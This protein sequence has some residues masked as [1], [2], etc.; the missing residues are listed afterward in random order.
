MLG[1]RAVAGAAAGLWLL[2]LAAVIIWGRP[3]ALRHAGAIVIMG[4]AQYRG[5]PSPVLRARLD[6][7][8]DLWVQKLA[9]RVVLTGGIA[10]GDTTS[11]AAVGQRYALDR[12]IPDS[13]V[14]LET[15]GRTTEESLRGVAALMATQRSR[16]VILVS[17]PFHM[18]RLS[19]L[20]RRL[21]LDPQTSPTQTSP[22]SSH[23]LEWLKYVL[24]ESIKVPL[25]LV[26]DRHP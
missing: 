20:A 14:L 22:I 18:L 10:E 21:G 15:H 4:A 8:I 25:V 24:G 1:F 6:H 7:G 3:H 9:D 13:A 16:S 2:S 11:E 12:G 19:I 5:K 23:R 26:L 17:D